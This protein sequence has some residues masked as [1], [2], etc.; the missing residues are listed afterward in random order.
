MNRQY[1]RIQRNQITFSK[2]SNHKKSRLL[3]WLPWWFHQRLHAFCRTS[4]YAST[5]HHSLSLWEA[6]AYARRTCFFLCIRRDLRRP[7]RRIWLRRCAG[8]RYHWRSTG[9]RC[10]AI[11]RWGLFDR[12]LQQSFRFSYIRRVFHTGF[13]LLLT[14]N[15]LFRERFQWNYLIFRIKALTN[16][17]S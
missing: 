9:R 1:I 15:I 8:L 7:L 3:L 6:C 10:S 16:I 2:W 17:T 4:T 14:S 12:N 5:L 13:V 11:R